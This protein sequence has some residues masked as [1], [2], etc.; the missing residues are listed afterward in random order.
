MQDFF[1]SDALDY[2]PQR[3]RVQN[4]RVKAL[5][6]REILLAAQL[7]YET[8]QLRKAIQNHC[9]DHLT[10][11]AGAAQEEHRFIREGIDGGDLTGSFHRNRIPGF[12]FAANGIPPPASERFHQRAFAGFRKGGNVEEVANNLFNAE[13]QRDR[14][15]REIQGSGDEDVAIAE[16]GGCIDEGLSLRK[17]R[18]LQRHLKKVVGQASEPVAVHPTICTKRED[19]K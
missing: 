13:M 3:R 11:E 16:L 9:Q 1:P 10:D 17:N 6:A 4:L 18:R 15:D 14:T 7:D 19:V 8:L 12:V 5:L 2:W